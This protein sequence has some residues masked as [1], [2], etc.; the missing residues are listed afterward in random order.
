MSKIL[1]YYAWSGTPCIIAKLTN[2]TGNGNAWRHRR[3]ARGEKWSSLAPNGAGLERRTPVIGRG[4]QNGCYKYLLWVGR[5]YEKRDE[6]GG[7]SILCF[8]RVA[9]TRDKREGSAAGH[10]E[11][12]V[13][14][15]YSTR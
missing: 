9:P 6:L 10:K 3:R 13:P 7:E 2:E 5:I 12:G 1:G 11:P 4:D 8:V 15:I 14:G